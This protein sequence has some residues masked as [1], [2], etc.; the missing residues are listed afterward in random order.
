MVVHCNHIYL[1]VVLVRHH[2]F[3]LR[4]V[5]DL[6]QAPLELAPPAAAHERSQDEPQRLRQRLV[7]L[8][9]GGAQFNSE[10]SWQ[11]VFA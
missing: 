1:L 6:L 2:D 11:Y 8:G 7:V 4:G 3:G 5:V 10:K 9:E